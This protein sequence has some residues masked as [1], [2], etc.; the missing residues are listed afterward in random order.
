MLK[1]VRTARY[2]KP[3]QVTNRL[4][5]RFT[6]PR[7]RQGDAPALK[8]STRRWQTVAPLPAS[9]VDAN[10]ACFLN[11]PGPLLQWQNPDKS[12][13]WLYNLHYFDDLHAEHSAQRATTHRELISHWLLGNPPMDGVGWE[14]Y[15]L[16]LRIVSWV[17]WLLAGNEPVTGMLD[18]LSQQAHVLRQQLE[19]HLQ[20][21][22]LLANAKA[23]V[24][25]GSC[26]EGEDAQEWLRKGLALLD[27]QHREQLLADGAHFELSP[28]YHSI[29]L[30]DILDVVQLGQCYRG[31]E[32][33][34]MNSKLRARAALMAS[35]LEGMLHP[36]GGIPFFN[37]ASFGITPEPQAILDYAHKLGVVRPVADGT[38]HYYDASGYMAVRQ[39]NQ[40]ALLDVAAIGPDYIP[41]HA[42]ADTLSF[43][44]SLF[45]ERVLVN[46]GISE[47]GLSAERLRQRGTAAHNTV[48]VNGK[49]SSEVWSGFRVARRASPFEVELRTAEASTIVKGSH[50]GYQRLRPKVTHSREWRVEPGALT[51]KDSLRGEYKKAAAFFHIHPTV[52]VECEA[53]LFVLNLPGGQRCEVTVIGGRAVLDD[54]TWHP[55]FGLSRPNK[56]IA[57]TF[58]APTIETTF[59]Y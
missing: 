46:S 59:S 39:H 49:D 10:T 50:T 40:V 42:H 24:F 37:D 6:K 3:V 22:H 28:M 23:L 43:E 15:P 32:I 19:Y 2:L 31:E 1:L 36:D 29:I 33:A 35:W 25:A 12:H 14:P 27:E 38:T 13:L 21:N 41:G 20:G 16:S 52:S 34:R 56:R 47:Y 53:E 55:E 44:W 11:E 4:T 57:V 54:S 30:M 7:L 17:K 58:L 48:V 45:G 9:V 8:P 5:R 51:V 26:F 18:S